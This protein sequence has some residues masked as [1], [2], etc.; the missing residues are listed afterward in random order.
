MSSKLDDVL[1]HL[2]EETYTFKVP[3][4]SNKKEVIE[5]RPIKTKDQKILAVKKEEAET[6]LEKYILIIELLDACI[7]KNSIPLGNIPFEDFLWILINFRSRSFGEIVNISTNC[8]HCNYQKNSFNINLEKERE[9][10][11]L[12][13]IKNA[14]I[15]VSSKLNIELGFVTLE[16]MLEILEFENEEAKK[17]ATLASM[18]KQAEFDEEI[19]EIDSLEDRIKLLENFSKVQLDEFEKFTEAN[20]F[21]VKYK[22]KFNCGKLDMEKKLIAGCGKE[23]EVELEGY[24]IID[25]F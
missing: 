1:K 9:I 2:D 15:R 16:D 6:D 24:D 4:L 13:K 8:K 11:Y 5:I 10:I 21:G 25:F 7:V 20:S 17:I 12:D 22:T 3:L 19:L 23:N 18:I 14:K